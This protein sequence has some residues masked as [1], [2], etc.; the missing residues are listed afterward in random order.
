[1]ALSDLA[2]RQAKA[3]G[4]K[5]TLTDFDGLGLYVS[6]KGGKAWLSAIT[7]TV[8]KSAYRSVSVPATCTDLSTQLQA[9]FELTNWFTLTHSHQKMAKVPG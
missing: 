5:F 8:N 6:P 1:M 9:R 4:K 7:G 3:T 2:V